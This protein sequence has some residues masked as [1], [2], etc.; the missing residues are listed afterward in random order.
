MMSKMGKAQE[1]NRIEEYNRFSSLLENI[2]NFSKKHEEVSY[3]EFDYYVVHDMILFSIEP[4]FDFEKLEN[5][6]FHL[7]KALPAIKR[8]FKKPIIFL[9]D[10]EDILPVENT[11]IINQNTFLHLA[12]HSHYVANITKKG[13]KPRKLLTRIYEDEYGIYENIIFCN[14]I[15]ETLS[16]IKKNKRTLNSIYY[17]SNIMKFNLLEKGNHV[18]YFL[19]LGKLH[20][21]YIRD[22]NQYFNVSKEMLKE[23]SSISKVIKS[24]LY[25]P[26][27]KKNNKRNKNLTLKK[28]N[29]F[30]M[31]KD[32]KQ[33]YKT[34]RLLLGNQ[35]KNKETIIPF[36]YDSMKKEYLTYVRLLSIFT[37]GHFNFSTSS[38]SKINLNL[39]D[40]TFN[41][42][43]WELKI[44]NNDKK[45]LLLHFTKDKSYRILLTNNQ[46][47]GELLNNYKQENQLDEIVFVSQTD[48][49]YLER[50]DVYIGVQDIDSFRRI[51][52]IILRGMIYADTLRDV[53]PFCGGHLHKEHYHNFYQCSDCMI[54]IKEGKCE[55]TKQ[56]FFYTDNAF[57]KK[58]S[59][60]MTNFSDDDYWNYERQVESLMH[61][62]N[63]TRINNN[64]D[65]ICPHCNKVHDE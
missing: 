9:K 6:I 57:R 50:N 25:K 24:R 34:Y 36:D 11:R 27:Y 45:E 20:T 17:A 28:T 44:A 40:V 19:A 4:D 48:E 29:I 53:C 23:L 12:S 60:T 3:I 49:S 65:V 22:F 38:E 61:F 35:P 16:L 10:T 26:V 14:F 62:R 7:K 15:D 8:I 47:E 56:Q 13:I 64:G 42:K 33:V 63:I 5:L 2:Q 21:G 18:N 58:Q 41:F 55:E 59:I 54:Q 1:K 43:D 52:Q 51:Q 39:L 46:Y 32:Y 31:Q 37:V 30:M